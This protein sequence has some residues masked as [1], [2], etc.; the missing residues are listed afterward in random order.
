MNRKLFYTVFLLCFGCTKEPTATLSPQNAIPTYAQP[1]NRSSPQ[2]I[3]PSSKFNDPR[4]HFQTQQGPQNEEDNEDSY[5]DD[6]QRQDVTG[7]T[8]QEGVQLE[9]PYPK[10]YFTALPRTQLTNFSN[11]AVRVIKPQQVRARVHVALIPLHPTTNQPFNSFDDFL[12]TASVSGAW[13]QQLLAVVARIADTYQLT[14]NHLGYRLGVD[15]LSNPLTIHMYGGEPLNKTLLRQNEGGHGPFVGTR[16]TLAYNQIG[17]PYGKQFAEYFNGNTIDATNAKLIAHN[18]YA[19]SFPDRSP[20][21]GTHV[22]VI[23]AGPFISSYGFSKKATAQQVQGLFAVM[24]NTIQ[25]K[26]LIG[27][28]YRVVT[29]TGKDANHTVPHFHVHIGRDATALAPLVL[30][31]NKHSLFAIPPQHALGFVDS[32]TMVFQHKNAVDKAGLRTQFAQRATT[33]NVHNVASIK[34]VLKIVSQ[35]KPRHV[36]FVTDNRSVAIRAW[37][38]LKQSGAAQSLT[39]WVQ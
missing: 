26:G 29:N 16:F 4:S 30:A 33:H 22:L 23:P 21:L 15:N 20:Q 7:L 37:Q 19:L 8:R 3:P 17:G 32:S 35:H 5:D 31:W 28:P 14:H 11:P 27:T 36:L 24:Q 2:E 12:N 6:S 1:T 18:Q 38:K 34:Q 13:S 25:Q 10:E 39:A 9:T